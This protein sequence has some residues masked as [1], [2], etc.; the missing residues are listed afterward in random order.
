MPRKKTQEQFENEIYIKT[1]GEYEVIGLYEGNLKRVNMI[2]HKCGTEFDIVPKFFLNGRT[3]CPKCAR[4]ILRTQHLKDPK[5]FEKEFKEVS[6]GRYT[7]ISPYI[8]N[9][10]K[11]K[12]KCNKCNNIFEVTPNNFLSKG[13]GCP[14]CSNHQ[15]K[16]TEGFSKLVQ[17]LGKGDYELLGDYKGSK[18]K[19]LFLHKSCG[20]TFKMTPGHFLRGHRCTSCSESKGESNIRLY[21]QKHNINFIYQFRFEDCRIVYPLPFDFAIFDGKG[22]LILL[23]EFDGKQHYKPVRFKGIP[24]DEAIKNFNKTKKRDKVKD[25]Y[26]KNNKIK[27]LRI[28]YKDINRVDSILDMAIPS[29][30]YQG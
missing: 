2:H 29:Q 16:T 6:H 8:N 19:T 18:T 7:Q 25:D 3:R 10:L 27:L 17:E 4:E 12:V 14:V 28:S 26:C 30:A 11:I 9:R 24:E 13:S 21:L 1:N 5:V 23:I 20:N 15:P 22:K